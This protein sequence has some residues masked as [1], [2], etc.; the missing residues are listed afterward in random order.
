MADA[1]EVVATVDGPKGKAEILEVPTSA[2]DGGLQLEYVVAFGGANQTFRS[3]G[4]AYIT[5]GELAGAE[6]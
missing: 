2:G 6:T 1:G 4:E 3:L 5:A